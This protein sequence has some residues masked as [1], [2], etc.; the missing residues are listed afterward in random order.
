MTP[1]KGEKYDSSEAQ[2]LYNLSCLVK[3]YHKYTKWKKFVLSFMLY[4]C[5]NG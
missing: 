4:T 2:A 3:Y 1:E 5:N